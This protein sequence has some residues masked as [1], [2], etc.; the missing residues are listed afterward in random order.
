MCL[1]KNPYFILQTTVG[2]SV[3]KVVVRG[4]WQVPVCIE[5]AKH[6]DWV[7]L[8]CVLIELFFKSV[9]K[10]VYRGETRPSFLEP[11]LVLVHRALEL[12]VSVCGFVGQ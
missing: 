8:V 1:R 11:P 3:S 9:A 12:S 10:V 6:D 7:A 5:I 2:H 4:T